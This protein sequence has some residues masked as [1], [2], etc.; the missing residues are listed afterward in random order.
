MTP[1]DFPAVHAWLLTGYQHSRNALTDKRLGKAHCRASQYFMDHASIMPEPQRSALQVHLL[2]VDDER[3]GVMRP[4][5]AEPLSARRVERLREFIRREA[6]R[7][8]DS[9][10]DAA[11]QDAPV[12]AVAALTSQLPLIVLAE[13]IGLPAPLRDRFDPLWCTVVAPVGPGQ[14]GRDTYQQRLEELCAYIADIVSEIRAQPR[15]ETEDASSP[16]QHIIAAADGGDITA[17]ER[18]S[19]IFQLLVAGQDPVN[20]QLQLMLISLFSQPDALA[21]LTTDV[22]AGKD[23]SKAIEELLRYDSAFNLA[24]WRFLA[25]DEG[26]H[27]VDVPAGDSVIVALGAA[28]HD[29]AKF[30]DPGVLDLSRS[31][32][33]HLAFGHGPHSCPGAALARITLEETVTAL[34]ARLPG[35]ALGCPPDSLKWSHAPLTRAV[36]ALP[37]TYAR[38]DA[39][40]IIAGGA[41]T[42]D[43]IADQIMEILFRRARWSEDAIQPSP[44]DA[45]IQREGVLHFLRQRQPVVLALPGFPCKSPNPEKVAG[46]L[47]DEGERRALHE[48]EDLCVEITAVYPPGAQVII[49]SDGHVFTDVI[50]VSDEDI[51]AYGAAVRRLIAAENLPHLSVLDLSDLWGDLPFPA[52]RER[53]AEQWS[54]SLEQLRE[55]ARCGGETTRVLCGM[56]RFMLDDAVDL[57]EGP[58]ARQ[59]VAKQR[60]YRVLGR[61]RAWGEV[62]GRHLPDAIRLSIHPQ[63]LGAE[64]FGISLVKPGV[65]WVTP[66]HSVVLLDAEGKPRLLRH[67]EARQRG[68]PRRRDGSPVDAGESPWYFQED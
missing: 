3:H 20:A 15:H 29:P 41:I 23:I 37:L 53:L 19:I 42:D 43:A 40:S 22:L 2:H 65:Q 67:D 34:L 36:A 12:D 24:T 8:I 48:L 33:P 26:L 21:E 18:D 14:P 28:N 4:L 5:V 68:T 10:P 58:S 50:G 1:V 60:A 39:A 31:P 7:I 51:S 64:K 63:P 11:P 35:L 25:D 61:S 13:A 56:T 59:K 27:G 30:P 47:P 55:E 17:A 52:K 9:F 16:L 57:P 54:G 32:N 62:V 45:P 6:H 38:R 49:C 46:R 66:W 44:A